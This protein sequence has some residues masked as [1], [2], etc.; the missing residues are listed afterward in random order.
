VIPVNKW[1][2]AAIHVA[3]IAAL[4][5]LTAYALLA[6]SILVAAIA[7]GASIALGANRWRVHYDPDA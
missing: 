2:Y 1:R 7:I 6:K 4:I 3:A 5:E